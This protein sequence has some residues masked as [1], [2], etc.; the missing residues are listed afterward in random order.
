MMAGNSIT[1][2]EAQEILKEN[3]FHLHRASR[4]YIYVKMIKWYH[5]QTQ[6]I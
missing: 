1:F 3:G 5:W 4:H 2:K 6:N